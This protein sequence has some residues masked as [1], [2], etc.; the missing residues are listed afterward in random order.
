M[1][2]S[3]L[4]P[5][6]PGL[7]VQALTERGAAARVVLVQVVLQGVPAAPDPHHDVLPQDL[8]SKT[9]D[10]SPASPHA[11]EARGSQIPPLVL[12]PQGESG[13]P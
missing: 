5:S 1:H 3:P 8:H 11:T 13:W 10:V 12:S 7:G 6:Q 9:R 4:P 2:P